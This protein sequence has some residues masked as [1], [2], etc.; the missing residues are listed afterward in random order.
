M[1]EQA[2]EQQAPPTVTLTITMN[3]DMSGGRVD[4]PIDSKM[5]CYAMLAMAFEVV[6][7][8]QPGQGIAVADGLPPGALEALRRGLG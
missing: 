6:L 3:A 7:K 2:T 5:L 8:R 1:I 4:G